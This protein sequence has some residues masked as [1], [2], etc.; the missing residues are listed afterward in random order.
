[1]IGQI[2]YKS[3]VTKEDFKNA[4]V[5]TDNITW[6]DVPTDDINTAYYD[7]NIGACI[8]N[9]DNTKRG[10]FHV[11]FSNITIGDLIE[12]EC[13]VL[14]VS[15][16][17]SDDSYLAYPLI[18]LH[19]Y[20]STT[21]ETNRTHIAAK[22]AKTTSWETIR[23]THYVTA[24]RN[25]LS[26]DFGGYTSETGKFIIRNCKAKLTKARSNEIKPIQLAMD[27]EA[28]FLKTFSAKY[29][30]KNKICFVYLDFSVTSDI[31]TTTRIASGLPLPA[32]LQASN[33]LVCSTNNVF[34]YPCL[35]TVTTGG[36]LNIKTCKSGNYYYG[37]IVYP[38]L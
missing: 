13:E 18:G 23:L 2:E 22:Y 17:L 12:C 15:S 19:Y 33:L 20:D 8:I 7:D 1:M 31:T 14:R 4:L 5:K 28:T 34:D 36:N 30:I 21:N 9:K 27:D 11:F 24:N 3:I 25:Y 26:C 35:A 32:N 6:C 16:S 37:T 10:F 38:V 29:E